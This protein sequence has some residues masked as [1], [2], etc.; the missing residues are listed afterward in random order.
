VSAM[1]RQPAID[2]SRPM[3]PAPT[4]SFGPADDVTVPVKTVFFGDSYS[5]GAGASAPSARWTTLVSKDLDWIETNE[6]RGGTGYKATASTN[7]CGLD[8]CPTIG[9]MI[10]ASEADPAVVVISGGRNDGPPNADYEA[11]VQT[12]LQ[13]AVDKWPS[14]TVVVTSPIWDDDQPPA[15]FPDTIAAV[16]AAAAATPGVH[17]LDLG[18]PLFGDASFVGS[19]GVHPSDIG[20]RRIADA[21]IAG[22]TPIAATI[23]T[24]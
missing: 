20:Y 23:P 17:F 18:E 16:Q 22:W 8:Y 15:W 13:G 1:L 5:A 9:E 11:L 4:F 10:A 21:F 19:D 3:T 24:T 12:T 7:G 14:A 6:A 2:A